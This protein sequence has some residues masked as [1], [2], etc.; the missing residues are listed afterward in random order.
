MSLNLKIKV[1]LEHLS[2]RKQISKIY[3]KQ[4]NSKNNKFR[5]EDIFL[6]KGYLIYESGNFNKI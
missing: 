2:L 5:D 3:S 6:R 1:K 4:V